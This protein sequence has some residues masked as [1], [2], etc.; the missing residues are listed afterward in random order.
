MHA[1]AGK[2]L[3]TVK[4]SHTASSTAEITADSNTKGIKR[5]SSK[6]HQEHK[7]HNSNTAT[8]ARQQDKH[9]S[10]GRVTEHTQQSGSTSQGQSRDDRQMP[11]ASNHN[12]RH[13]TITAVH[14]Q[15]HSSTAERT[16]SKHK[17]SSMRPCLARAN[18]AVAATTWRAVTLSSNRNPRRGHS[19]SRQR[20]C[21]QLPLRANIPTIRWV[22]LLSQEH[23]SPGAPPSRAQHPARRRNDPVFRPLDGP[24]HTGDEPGAQ[25][26]WRAG[27]RRAVRLTFEGGPEAQESARR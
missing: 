4:V 16:S 23:G 18:A 7:Q 25:K 26:I 3:R 20:R 9:K 27:R 2:S 12:N 24:V 15:T 14:P 21:Q 13:T 10:N 8:A 17:R 6:H 5:V 1:K 19:A 22:N 11:R